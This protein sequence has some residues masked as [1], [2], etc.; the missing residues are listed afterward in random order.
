MI[1][2]GYMVGSIFG[3]LTAIGGEMVS[4]S[5]QGGLGH[6][7]VFFSSLIRMANVG[8]V[9]LIIAVLGVS[10]YVVFFF[11]GKRWASWEA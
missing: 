5:D 11:I 8:A 4:A 1:I 3:L 9:I 2:V 7:L 10:I 6:Q